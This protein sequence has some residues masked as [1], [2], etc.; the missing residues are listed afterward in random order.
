VLYCSFCGKSQHEVRTLIAGPTVFICDECT[1]L[2]QDIMVENKKDSTISR[3][4][5]SSITEMNVRFEDH[6]APEE[7][8]LLPHLI[9]QVES[10]FPRC[11]V[12]FTQLQTFVSADVVALRVE[13]PVEYDP[14]E[15]AKQVNDLSIK[16]RIEQQKYIAERSQREALESKLREVMD[17][18][19]PLL[20]EN[21]KKSGDY[22]GV[23]IETMSVMFIDIAGFSRMPEAERIQAVDL[24]RSLGRAL[25][26]SEKG[27]YLNTWGDAVVAAF[28]QPEAALRC[29]CKFSQHFGL[30]GLDARVGISWGAIRVS[31]NEIKGTQDI[32]GSA[33]NVGAR[34]ETLAQPGTV[35]CT[36]EVASLVGDQPGLFVFTP[37][38][39]ALKKAVGD[40]PAGADINIFEVAYLG[41]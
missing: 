13:A 9:S 2:C 15:L 22:P 30:M 33:V 21:L 26:R 4:D 31:V 23:K 24:L 17:T 40:L 12:K 32:D 37:R 19:Y 41:N 29:G 5:G 38:Q 34:I 16:L 3:A 6:L 8:A 20:I 11:T 14:Q 7:I 27:M 36:E 39:A 1:D 18:V 35:V 10:A 25:L 28:D